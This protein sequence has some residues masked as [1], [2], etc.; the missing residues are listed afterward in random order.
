MPIL[1]TILWLVLGLGSVMGVG[2]YLFVIKR[3]RV[4]IANIWEKK[5][6]G[7]LHLIGRDK[8][9]ERKFNKGKQIAYIMPKYK[10]EVFPPPWEATYRVFNKEYADYIRIR[11]DDYQPA[12]KK[13]TLPTETM[14]DDAKKIWFKGIRTKLHELRN[15]TKAEIESEFVYIPVN[16]VC[17]VDMNFDIMDYDINMMR[18]NAIDNRDKIYS[19]K[20][21]WLEKYGMYL[22]MGSIIVLI[23]IVLYFSYD[24]SSNV[25]N[26]AMGKATETLSMVE[27]LAS[28]MGG[29][30]PAS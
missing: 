4:W 30:P 26:S 21:E 22:A 27:Q 15:K 2:Y 20:R 18:I 23:I 5:A 25:I 14:T 28:K 7:R 24:Y 8:V 9:I 29:T 3:R 10:V 11:E 6:D 1:K 12:K 16:N 17:K 19:D 13:L